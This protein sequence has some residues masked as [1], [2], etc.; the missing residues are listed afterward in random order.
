[1]SKGSEQLKSLVLELYG[2]VR[3]DPE[4]VVGENLRLDFY[5]PNYKLG[6]E[7]HGRQHREFVEHFHKDAGGFQD[8]Q[9][10]DRRKLELCA[11]AG[12][13]VAVFWDHEKLSLE[14]VKERIQEALGEE[15]EIF[16]EPS[17]DLI[18]KRLREIKQAQ[19]QKYKNSPQYSEKKEQA[20]KARKEQY[21]WMKEHRRG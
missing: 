7:Y 19:Y 20:R 13:S 12:I 8:S 16:V 2:D 3:I 9:K 1:M 4:Y 14:L 10:R 17:E 6:L 18:K 5:L 15:N 11:M 21:Q